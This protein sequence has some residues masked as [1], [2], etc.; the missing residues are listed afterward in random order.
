VVVVVV[1]EEEEEEFFGVTCSCRKGWWVYVESLSPS[2]NTF[3]T[4]VC[5]VA[6]SLPEHILYLC[7]SS[8]SLPSRTHSIPPFPARPFWSAISQ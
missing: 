8:L 2:Q 6:L 1:V 7:M 5:R 4:S 3:Y